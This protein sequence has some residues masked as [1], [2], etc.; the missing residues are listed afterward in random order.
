MK[1][2]LNWV[3]VAIA[4]IIVSYVVPGIHV[5]GFK[6]A[7]IVAVLLSIINLIIRPILL[8]LTL[9]INILTLGL[10]TFVLNGILLA[11]V[12]SLVTGFSITGLLPAI[13][14]A[15][16]LSIVRVIIHHIVD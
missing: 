11:F 8:L 16:V 7:F 10:F 2:L 14:A 1:L 6:A 13:I 3:F 9:P 15:L 12:A 5:D 4:L